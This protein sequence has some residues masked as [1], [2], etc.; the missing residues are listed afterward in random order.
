MPVLFASAITPPLAFGPASQ[1]VMPQPVFE[2]VVPAD[3]FDVIEATSVEDS[4]RITR[5][6]MCR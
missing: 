2:D 5:G 3:V 4:D 1:M 6:P